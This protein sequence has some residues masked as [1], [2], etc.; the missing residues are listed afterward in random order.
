M[1][2]ILKKR[3]IVRCVYYL[4]IEIWRCKIKQTKTSGNQYRASGK[5]H[6]KNIIG[7]RKNEGSLVPGKQGIL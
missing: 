4:V 2:G 5:R 3:R 1:L 6:T 7:W